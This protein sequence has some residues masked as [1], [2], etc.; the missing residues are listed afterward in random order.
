MIKTNPVPK[1]LPG[2]PGPVD[3]NQARKKDMNKES[4]QSCAIFE[5]SEASRIMKKPF[6]FIVVNIVFKLSQESSDKVADKDHF[7]LERTENG[8]K[9][10]LYCP[11]GY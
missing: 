3:D 1:H 7:S 8:E 6:E 10:R 9:N 5:S 4:Y 11:D 2:L